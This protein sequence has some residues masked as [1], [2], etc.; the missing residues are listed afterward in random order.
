MSE[1][2]HGTSSLYRLFA[3]LVIALHLNGCNIDN[4]VEIKCFALPH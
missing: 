1:T 4:G 3:L 2:V